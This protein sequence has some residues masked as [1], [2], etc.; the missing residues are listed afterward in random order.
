[1]TV[2][3]I[4]K[5]RKN[6]VGI[7]FCEEFSPVQLGLKTDAA[8]LWAIDFKYCCEIGLKSGCVLDQEQIIQISQES[9]FRRAY[10][11]ALWYLEHGDCSKKQLEEKL[12][13]SFDAQTSLRAAQ[14]AVDSGFVDDEKYARRLAES[15]INGKKVAPKKAV[16]MLCMKGIDRDVAKAAVEGIEVDEVHNI[17]LLIEAKYKNRVQKPDD[18]QKTVVALAR[19]GFSFGDIR[20]ALSEYNSDIEMYED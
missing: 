9:E 20:A 2:A 11:R 6:L 4:H 17:L 1:M 12:Q 10:S 18:I 16:Y 15:L 19:R 3:L 8:G 14:K 7:E 5:R 13:R